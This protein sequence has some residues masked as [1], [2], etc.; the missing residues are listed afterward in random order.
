MAFI[1]V[2]CYVFKSSR[3]LGGLQHFWDYWECSLILGCLTLIFSVYMLKRIIYQGTK[4]KFTGY[5]APTDLEKNMS[6]YFGYRRFIA[7]RAIRKGWNQR[8]NDNRGK[9]RK[10]KDTMRD[11]STG[12]G[13]VRTLSDAPGGPRLPSELSTEIHKERVCLS[14]TNTGF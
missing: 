13:S 2:P 7:H 14:Q 5:S 1:R 3:S 8:K 6:M 10:E 9:R 11:Y 12:A 4:L